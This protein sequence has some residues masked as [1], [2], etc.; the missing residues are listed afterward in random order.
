MIKLPQIVAH[1]G[2]RNEFPEN[3]SAS[4][5]A[6]LSIAGVSG[7]EFDVELADLPLVL[8]QETVIPSDDFT[9]IT[10]AERNYTSRNWVSQYK[11]DQIHN[12]DAGSWFDQK[13]SFLRIPYLSEIL[14]LNWQDRVAHVELKDPTFWNQPDQNWPVKMVDAVFGQIKPF[15]KLNRVSILS[16]NPAILREVKSR[17]SMLPLTFLIWTEWR[18]K[19]MEAITLAREIGAT[20]LSVPDVLAL[21]S[22]KWVELCHKN[23]L[24]LSVY[25]VS[26]VRG[27]PEYVHWTVESQLFKWKRLVELQIDLLITDFPRETVKYLSNIVQA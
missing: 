6:A 25:P 13:F 17:D 12:L 3:T 9:R 2:A 19:E 26:P 16:F 27:E 1:R 24:K 4:I 11:A 18:D 20:T 8:H 10:P 7:V 5:E 22:K 15:S 21:D 23:E 14:A